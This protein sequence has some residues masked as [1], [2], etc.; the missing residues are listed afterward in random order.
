MLPKYHVEMTRKALQESVSAT[1]LKRIVGANVRQDR[2]SGQVG[3][4]EFHFDNNAFEKSYAYIEEQRMLITTSLESEDAR[5]AWDAF[6]RLTHT[7]QDFYSHS[8]YVDLWISC[9]PE[10]VVP[11][12]SE[13]DPVKSDLI[14]THAL[15]SGRIYFPLEPLGFIPFLRPLVLRFLPRDSHAWMNLDSPSQG[16]NFTF[17]FHAAIKRTKFEFEKTIAELPTALV[18][19]FIDQ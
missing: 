14:N 4:D 10:G 9:Q 11:T 8:N 1:A 17:A 15:C 3:H 19:K 2:L 7:A 16:P 12:P 5:S 18:T 6:G 13:I